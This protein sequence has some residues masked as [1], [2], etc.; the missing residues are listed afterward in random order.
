GRWRFGFTLSSGVGGMSMAPAYCLLA[1]ERAVC[2]AVGLGMI[3]VGNGL[4]TPNISSLVGKLYPPGDKRVDSAF[5][6][7][8]MGINVGALVAPISAAVIV[9][10]V[11]ART[12]WEPRYAYLAVFA[13]AAVGMLL[14]EIIYLLFSRWVIP[15]QPVQSALT[16]TAIAQPPVPPAVQ[17]RRNLA[18]IVFFCINILFWMAF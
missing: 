7:F 4:F 16:P 17:S 18:L 12:T 6:I 9:N 13:V 1:Q 3:M 11:G 8:Y 14:G 5:S 15:V 2:V 10:L